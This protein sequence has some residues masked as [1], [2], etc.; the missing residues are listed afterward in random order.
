MRICTKWTL[1]HV[2]VDPG[3]YDL[4]GL[5]WNGHYVVIMHHRGQIFQQLCDAVRF[6]M[7]NKGFTIIDYIDDYISIGIPSV[8]Q[9]SYTMLICLMEFHHAQ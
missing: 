9:E 5:R 8:A 7:R 2:R 4:L 6:I 1:R 3:D